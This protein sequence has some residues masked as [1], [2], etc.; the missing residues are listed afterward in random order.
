MTANLPLLLQT[1][2]CLFLGALAGF[3]LT[4]LL[5]GRTHQKRAVRADTTSEIVFLFDGDSL[6]DASETGADLLNMTDPIDND[7]ARITDILNARFVGL[8]QAVAACEID[9]PIQ[10]TSI[11]G[12]STLT[13][14]QSKTHL[15]L[16]LG[17][18]E[19]DGKAAR[20]EWHLLQAA[21]D[22]LHDHRALSANAPFPMWSETAEGRI[23]WV[24]AEYRRLEL[25]TGTGDPAVA[26]PL[27]LFQIETD[28]AGQSAPIQRAKLEIP[29]AAEPRW[30]EFRIVP[31][32]ADRL[33]IAA[34]IDRVIKAEQS[35]RDFVQTLTQTF[36]HLNVGLAIFGRGRELAIF[37]PALVDL[38]DL[39][40]EFLIKRPTLFEVFDCLREKR[41]MPEPKDYKS[42]LAKMVALEA[43]AADGCI[44]E[45]W[46]L[47]DGRTY[48]LTGR[49][50]PDGA[51]AFLFE[52]ISAEITLER[53]FRTDLQLGQAI[54]DS[55]DEAI[56]V[57]TPA[58]KLTQWN[59]AF[60]SLW[61]FDEGEDLS[62][63]SFLE[64]SRRWQEHCVP[65]PIWGDARDF[66]AIMSERSNW[67]A[68]ARTRTGRKLSCR[69]E[70]LAGGCTMV[71]FT[72]IDAAWNTQQTMTPQS[73]S[74]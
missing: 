39:S 20:P 73:K 31:M 51:V 72:D 37:N 59:R 54:I 24:N 56:A 45:T 48:R 18:S 3:G 58:G 65:T 25:E 66:A 49:P 29:E 70:A 13:L 47:V 67:T 44:T 71:G 32:G 15:R 17:S 10:L 68:D 28:I 41:L 27:R 43:A 62:R 16:T 30:F 60:T 74:A 50:H 26:T 7:L 36:A 19:P 69:F 1:I 14:H 55:L 11:N 42:W 23:T 34:P 5:T 52:D 9:K 21:T 22:K 6:V 57:F 4:L 53:R 2:F 64:A 12:E 40:P 46:S 61:R 63:L 33:I 38:L 35:L 8:E